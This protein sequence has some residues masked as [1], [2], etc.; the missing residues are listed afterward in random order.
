MKF[1]ILAKTVR[2]TES[3]FNPSQQSKP[4][5]KSFSFRPQPLAILVL[6]SKKQ[7]LS[8][9][10]FCHHFIQHLCAPAEVNVL[11]D[12]GRNYKSTPGPWSLLSALNKQIETKKLKLDRTIKEQLEQFKIT[13]VCNCSQDTSSLK[14][15]LA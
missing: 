2:S 1:L 15:Q 8:S 6:L 12:F 13:E 9:L 10:I 4:P 7:F 11:T 5:L 3:C 14:V